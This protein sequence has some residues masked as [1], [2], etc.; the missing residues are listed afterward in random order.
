MTM[1]ASLGSSS[2][3]SRNWPR[4]EL[5][6]RSLRELIRDPESTEKAFDVLFAIGRGD[7]ERQFRRFAGDPEGARLLAER[8]S[9]AVALRDRAALACMPDGSLGRAYLEYLDRNGF[10]A[11][12]L[13]SVE[14]TVR[15]R[16]ERDGNLPPLDEQR[17]WFRDRIILMHDLF[18]VI[19]GRNTNPS[20]EGALLWFS[21]AQLGGGA[22]LFLTL[23]ATLE[24]IRVWGIGWLGEVRKSWRQG[25]GAR[26]LVTLP[27]EQLLPLPLE[28]VRG[29]AGVG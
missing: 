27:F 23:G 16:W 8:P 21:Q 4:F 24:L 15:A 22:N 11:E 29:M 26:W 25:R 19:T 28:T 20:D 6:A 9:L 7:F 13:V 2:D 17:S 18:H 10:Q 3:S 1:H 14:R 5:A 12:G